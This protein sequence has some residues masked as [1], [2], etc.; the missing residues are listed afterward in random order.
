MGSSAKLLAMGK[1]NGG[2]QC[3][4]VTVE[5][6]LSGA[7]ETYNP[8]VCDCEF[9]SKHSAAYLSDAQGSLV[10]AI[11]NESDV[12][13]YRQGSKTAEFI[14]CKQ[15]GVLVAI[16]HRT[17]EALFATLNVR[18]LDRKFEFGREQPVSPKQLASDEKAKRWR[19]LWFS[20]VSFRT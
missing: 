16:C 2:C 19:A 11:A 15:C 20:K 4:N 8:R 3:G 5:A 13:R 1:I 7:F 6:E 18:A 9:C 14:V 17:S 10:I 12:S